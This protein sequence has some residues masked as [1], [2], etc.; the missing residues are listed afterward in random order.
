LPG[1]PQRGAIP[2][3]SGPVEPPRGGTHAEPTR[4]DLTQAARFEIQQL[5]NQYVAAYR[6]MND[7]D[8]K[9]IDPS[10]RGIPRRELIK[11]V[12][13]TVG[14]PQIDVSP[15]GQAATLKASGSFNYVWNRAGLPP[16]TAAQLT[17]TLE[18]RGTRWTV[19]SSN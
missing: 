18:K 7:R 2:G 8:L 19:V 9:A 15:D 6:E 13:L 11:S 14:Q 1:D 3:G 10:F 17:W 5:L 16:T 4:P 12:S